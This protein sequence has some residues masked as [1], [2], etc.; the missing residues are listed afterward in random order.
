MHL[1]S[2]TWVY[3]FLFFFLYWSSNHN[4]I[5]SWTKKHP[6]KKDDA[7]WCFHM[8]KKLVKKKM[9]AI[10]M[11]CCFWFST[12]IYFLVITNIKLPSIYP[13]FGPIKPEH[14]H[15]HIHTYGFYLKKKSLEKIENIFFSNHILTLEGGQRLNFVHRVC[16]CGDHWS[17]WVI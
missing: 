4:L 10:Y 16:V 15:T 9:S 1:H 11:R 12:L 17:S 7:K 6:Q 14:T 3:H 2:F 13:V 5:F 8:W